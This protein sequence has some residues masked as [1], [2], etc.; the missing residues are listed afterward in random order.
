MSLRELLSGIVDAPGDVTVSDVTLD[1]RE[2]TPGALFLACRGHQQGNARH[3]VEFAA[4]AAAR[5]ARAVVYETPAADE[6]RALE[7]AASLRRQAQQFVVAVPDLRAH[8]GV[9]ADRFFGKPS[10]AL[11]VVGVTG[12]NGKTTCA[13][14]IAQALSLCARP[15]AYIGTIGYGTAAALQP[16][17]HTTADVLSV[18]RQ[19]AS[20]RAAG[21]QAVAMEVSSHALDQG[22]VDEVR[23]AAAAFTNLTQDHLDYHGTLQAYGAA[24]ARLF[25]RATLHSRVINVDDEFGRELAQRGDP[26]R[27]I[28]TRR[29]DRSDFPQDASHVTATRIRPVSDGFDLDLDSSWG[30]AR[31]RL[32]LIGEF[33]IDNALTT[34]AVLLAAGV[35]LPEAVAAL[36]QCVPAPGRMQVVTHGGTS[37]RPTVIV[38]YA[39]TPDALLKALT[40][41]RVHCRGRLQVVF[42]CGGD[43]DALK[44][45]IMGRIAVAHADAVIVTDDNPRT[46]DPA[47]IVRDIL[48]PLVPGSVRVEHDRA[49]A[50]REAITVANP[51]DV[52]LIAGK[53]HEDYQIQ[54]TMRRPFS[55][56][57]MA[58]GVLEGRS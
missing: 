47:A 7:A 52:V 13:W 56:V 48:A 27:L 4:Q 28:V 38:D 55:D 50:I 53:G 41:A 8:L 16:V 35:P 39:H 58:R 18:H 17:T 23:F 29:R 49:V 10:A 2:V 6:T 57:Q 22:R 37:A 44:R 40:A 21:A 26:G 31:L 24:K 20:L 3:G 5:G 45:P 32:P 9:I 46:E 43:R 14:L 25:A 11:H 15:A 30:N 51:G 33:N 34:L 36:G 42:G 1:S 19:L 12:T 54:G